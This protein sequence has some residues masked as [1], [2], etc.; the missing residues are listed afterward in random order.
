MDTGTDSM[1]KSMTQNQFDHNQIWISM[2]ENYFDLSRFEKS[3]RRKKQSIPVWES[4][5]ERKNDQFQFGR[6]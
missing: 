2:S 4:S 6:A 3:R 1:S 5:P